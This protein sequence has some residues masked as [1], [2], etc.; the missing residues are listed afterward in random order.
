VFFDEFNTLRE[1]GFFKE[2]IIDGRYLGV[3]LPYI[4]DVVMMAACNPHKK[5]A[6]N[7][8][9]QQAQYVNQQA[10]RLAFD[11]LPA[12][13]SLME[14]MWNYGSLTDYEYEKY[15]SKMLSSVRYKS[16][17]VV[18]STILGIHRIIIAATF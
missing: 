16:D 6:L 3:K 10:D 2:I 12:P 11:V 15:I 1:V 14:C 7:Q 4:H 9:Q 5:L 8:Q 17:A 18:A 13:H